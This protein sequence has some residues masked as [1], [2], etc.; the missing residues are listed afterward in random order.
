[1]GGGK[2]RKVNK[3]A[4]LLFIPYTFINVC[5]EMLGASLRNIIVRYALFN[6]T[7]DS[8]IS[9]TQCVMKF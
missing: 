7:W 4:R 6:P 1:M 3:S 5:G 2:K 8:G 9:T